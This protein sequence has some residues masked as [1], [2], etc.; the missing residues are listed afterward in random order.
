MSYKLYTGTNYPEKFESEEVIVQLGIHSNLVTKPEDADFF[1]FP[2]NYE[3]L[4]GYKEHEHKHYNYTA[5]E[6]ESLRQKLSA[7]VANAVKLDKKIILFYYYDPVDKINVP[8]SIIF[9]TSLL[10]SKKDTNEFALP[11]YTKDLRKQKNLTENELWLEKTD[12]PTIGFRGQSAP[13][14]LPVKLS[15]KRTVNQFLKKAG[16]NKQFNLYYNFGY[17]ARRDAIVSC[18]NNPKIKTDFTLTTLEQS[19]D[20]VNS[21]LPFV[22]NIFENQYNLC[23]SGH[24]NYSFRLYE[25]LSAGRIPVF[26]NTNCVL[27]FE[28]FTNWKKHVVWIEEKDASKA[29]QL[30]LDFHQTIHPD[31]FIQVQKNNRLFW[32]ENLSKKGFYQSLHQYFPLLKQI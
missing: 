1:V 18:L 23:V 22:N 31:D 9:R 13:L 10:K 16:I 5:E 7:M 26:I 32:K 3:K 15:I 12:R 19:W 6:I 21:K 30:I 8:N 28:E 20:P 17:L 24:G 25:I 4:Y 2:I 29:D 27:P 14:K 11:A